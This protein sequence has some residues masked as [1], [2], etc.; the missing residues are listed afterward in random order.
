MP[1]FSW[2]AQA[3]RH[4]TSVSTEK[5]TYKDDPDYADK[6]AISPGRVGFPQDQA[7]RYDLI[8]I[9]RQAEADGKP[10]NLH[11]LVR[12]QALAKGDLARAALYSA[13]DAT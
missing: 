11:E 10:S 6:V 3:A 7:E 4:D 9:A 13:A 12:E 2:A 8:L 5:R 1:F